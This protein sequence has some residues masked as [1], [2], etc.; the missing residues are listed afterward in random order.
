LSAMAL[1]FSWRRKMRGS[2]MMEAWTSGLAE[3]RGVIFISSSGALGVMM[4][5]CSLRRIP[6]DM[7]SLLGA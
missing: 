2:E 3:H 1:G 5:Q 6:N 7:V 4:S